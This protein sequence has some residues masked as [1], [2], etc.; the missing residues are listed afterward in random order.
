MPQR[1]I[2]RESPIA[3]AMD[4]SVHGP[5]PETTQTSVNN[6]VVCEQ[7]MRDTIAWSGL[8]VHEPGPG[9]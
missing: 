5:L 6:M 3:L 1:V 9:L 2:G 7:S 4:L 8:T